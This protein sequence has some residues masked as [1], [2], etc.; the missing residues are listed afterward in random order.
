MMLYAH[1]TLKC[2]NAAKGGFQDLKR[3]LK[4]KKKLND[5]NERS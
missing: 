1:Y 2:K 3:F 5:T 4:K